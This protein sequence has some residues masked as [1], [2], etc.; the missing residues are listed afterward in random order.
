MHRTE[1]GKVA[2][3]RILKSCTKQSS[4]KLHRTEFAKFA[5][6]RIRKSCTEQNSQKVHRTELTIK[7]IFCDTHRRV[8]KGENGTR[9]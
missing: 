5:Q 8:S 1:F 3:N 9:C 4:Q 6:N 2:Q 7:Y